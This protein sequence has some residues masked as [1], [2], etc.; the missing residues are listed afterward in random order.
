MKII[1]YRTSDPNNK[2][3]K[4]LNNDLT[5]EGYLISECSIL[6]PVIE[7]EMTDVFNYNYAYIEEFERYY[8]ITDVVS[9]SNKIWKV[10]FHVDVLMTYN[11]DIGVLRA[12]ILR[13]VKDY[14]LLI[15]DNKLKTYADDRV[16]C[17]NF[18]KPLTIKDHEGY[19]TNEFKYYLALIGGGN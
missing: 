3:N 9:V 1:L 15:D 10:S 13:T 8:F 14:N 12:P 11:N 17:Y 2:L 19:V 7:I 4:T 16:Q 6:R 18:P 5:L